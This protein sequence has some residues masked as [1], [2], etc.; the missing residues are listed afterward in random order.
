L[1]LIKFHMHI[2]RL[3]VEFHEDCLMK[4]FMD[5]LEGKERLWYEGLK[6]CSLYSLKDF[7]IT[8]FKYYG[9]SDPSFLVF[10]DCCEFCEGF[11]QYLENTFGDEECMNDEIIEALYEHLSQ[12]QTI[13]PPLAEDGT[14]Q[15][16]VAETHFPSPKFYEDV[17]EDFQQNIVSPLIV[18]QN[19]K[20]QI[21]TLIPE[22]DEDILQFLENSKE[23]EKCVD[24]LSYFETFQSF[25]KPFT[26][27]NSEL[28]LNE[29]LWPTFSNYDEGFEENYE[30]ENVVRDSLDN[31]VE[32]PVELDEELDLQA[33]TVLIENCQEYTNFFPGKD[34]M[35]EE[36]IEQVVTFSFEDNLFNDIEQG[37]V[38]DKGD[39][40]GNLQ[41]AFLSDLK[42]PLGSLL[43][44]SEKE[45]FVEFMDNGDQFQL[46]VESS[47]FKFLFLFGEVDCKFQSQSHC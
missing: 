1:H 43:E 37:T 18:D 24:N 30:E 31:Q 41:E 10:E 13:T 9:E 42:D 27:E 33:A 17:H 38:M 19:S 28:N 11:I 44:L 12:Q 21:H 6:P 47:Y 22:N 40:F 20:V 26:Q 32:I 8:F 4:M 46:Y 25:P 35:N 23:Q 34:D 5:T 3:G 16:L 2:C 7:H 14:D 45:N 36:F 29:V 39:L 15:E